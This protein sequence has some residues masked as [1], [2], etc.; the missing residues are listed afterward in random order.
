MAEAR[1]RL[2]AVERENEIDVGT[3]LTAQRRAL[4]VRALILAEVEYIEC[5][6]QF[7]QPLARC[8]DGEAAKIAAD[9]APP[10]LVRY[11]GGCP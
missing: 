10:E 3:K 8:V 7:Q 5:G 1:D 11:R 9:L 6:A 4:P 2:R